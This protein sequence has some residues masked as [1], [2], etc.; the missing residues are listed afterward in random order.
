MASVITLMAHVKTIFGRCS[1]SLESRG[2]VCV[3]CHI[4]F[5][6]DTILVWFLGQTFLSRLT[7][8][9]SISISKDAETLG[10][11]PS[12]VSSN[13]I[14]SQ[15]E[16]Q[17]LCFIEWRKNVC[18]TL[19]HIQVTVF[20]HWLERLFSSKRSLR[21]IHWPIPNPIKH[22]R[23]AKS[24]KA[25][26]K[27]ANRLMTD[28]MR[29]DKYMVI[30]LPNL[31][32]KGPTTIPPKKNPTKIMDDPMVPY[33]PRSHTRSNYRQISQAVIRSKDGS[34]INYNSNNKLLF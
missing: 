34:N 18:R 20:H 23:S 32:L 21:S 24:Q 29:P 1:S 8:I 12:P 13:V 33:K 5:E 3:Q 6:V 2:V 7:E 10:T 28:K 19:H 27:A 16:L 15:H 26:G 17:V 11:W 22:L 25:S 4:C 14:C 9:I 31:S 30:F